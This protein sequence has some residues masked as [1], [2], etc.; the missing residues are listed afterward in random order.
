[1]SKPVKEMVTRDLTAR[2]AHETNAVWVE[3]VGVD[4][5]TTNDFR[6][7]L[8]GKHMRLEVVKTALL[9]RACAGGPL[10]KLTDR[11]G[12]PVALIT[13]GESAVTVAKL[14]DDWLPKLQPRLRVRGALL[15]GEYLDEAACKDL[16]RMPTR[17]DLLGRVV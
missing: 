11:V 2:F 17:A 6:R 3:L 4:G 10:A 14:L 7:A 8:R 12:G 13:G 9:K 5:I 15:D 16:A 1:M